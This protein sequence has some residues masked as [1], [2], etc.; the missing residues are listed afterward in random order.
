VRAWMSARLQSQ[1]MLHPASFAIENDERGQPVVKRLTAP[2]RISIAHCE[3]R[4]IAIAQSGSIGVDIERI[5]PRNPGFLETITSEAERTLLSEQVNVTASSEQAEEW[6]TRI[7]CA[8]EVVGKLRGVGVS[9][10]QRFQVTAIASD[11]T[12]QIHPTDSERPVFVNTSRD[13]TFIIAH[14]MTRSPIE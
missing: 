14:A 12:L 8:K 1:E 3:D 10:P 11:G 4:A 13:N 6:I 5:S 7:W 9:V 2:P